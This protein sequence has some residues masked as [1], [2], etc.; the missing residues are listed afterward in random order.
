ML[1]SSSQKTEHNL[2]SSILLGTDKCGNIDI[3]VT[4]YGTENL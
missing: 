1:W 4:I 2:V 3:P